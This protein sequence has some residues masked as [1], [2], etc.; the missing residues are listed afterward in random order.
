[1]LP[2]ANARKVL[3]MPTELGCGNVQGKHHTNR[4]DMKIIHV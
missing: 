1:M 4:K 3:S 2:T